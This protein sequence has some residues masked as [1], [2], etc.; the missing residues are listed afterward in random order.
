MASYQPPSEFLPIFDNT[1][2]TATNPTSSSGGLTLAQANLLYLRK[3]YPDVCT[4]LETFNGGIST[5][6]LTS[7][8]NIT[9]PIVSN[10]LSAVL[11]SDTV[12]VYNNLTNGVLNIGTNA[13]TANMNIGTGQTNNQLSIGS[14][15]NTQTNIY[16]GSVYLG[17]NTSISGTLGAN[18]ITGTSYTGGPVSGTTFTCTSLNSSG[19]TITGGAISGTSYS[20]GTINGTSITGTS[21][22][23]TG[24]TITG[25]AIT[26]TS[27]SG[28]SITGTSYSGGTVNGTAFTSTSLNTTNGNITMGTGNIVSVNNIA[29]SGTITGGAITG[30][31]YSGGT[32]N[33]TAFTSTSLNTTNGNITMGTGNIVSVNN[34]AAS[35][36]ITGTFTGTVSS[37]AIVCTSLDATAGIIK[38]TGFVRTNAYEGILNNDVVEL[39]TN[40]VSGVLSFGNNSARTANI[41]IGGGMT[42]GVLKLGSS[43][44]TRLNG[45]TVTIT[46]VTTHNNNSI[47]NGNIYGNI[48]YANNVGDSVSFITNQTGGLNSL[49]I[50]SSTN[51]QTNIYG[52]TVSLN[53][54]TSIVGTF[55]TGANSIT[56]TGTVNAGT[57]AMGSGT[58][59]TTG[60][61]NAG[62]LAMGSGTITTTGTIN[63]G[64][65]AMGTGNIT[66]TG[67]VNCTT[68]ALAGVGGNITGTYGGVTQTLNNYTIKG[69]YNL[70]LDQTNVSGA[71]RIGAING[72]V[73]IGKIGTITQF[74]GDLNFQ[75]T[76]TITGVGNLTSNGT[77]TTSI[78]K[79]P[80]ITAVTSADSITIGGDITTGVISLGTGNALTSFIN[81][82]TGTGGAG[83]YIGS[84]SNA[85]TIGNAMTVQGLLVSNS[86][87]TGTITCSGIN[88]ATATATFNLAG[89]QTSGDVNIAGS[90]TFSGNINIGISATGGSVYIGNAVSP[91]RVIGNIY[92]NSLLTNAISDNVN[93]YTTNTTGTINFGTSTTRT[94]AINIGTNSTTAA[95]GIT[96]GNSFNP[97]TVGGNLTVTGTLTAGSLAYTAVS[98][99]TINAR[100]N[101]STVNLYGNLETGPLNLACSANRSSGI[102]IGT[103]STV[104]SSD[105]VLGSS[106]TNTTVNGNLTSTIKVV[107]P[108]INAAAAG[109]TVSLYNTS[110]GTINFGNTG[111]TTTMAGAL[112]VTQNLTANGGLTLGSNQGIQLGAVPPTLTTS[113]LGYF[114]NFPLRTN[115]GLTSSSAGY[116]YNP[117][118]NTA[119][120]G[121]F[122]KAGV[123]Y[124]TINVIYRFT[125]SPS[126][127]GLN[128]TFGISSSTTAG[129]ATTS[130]NTDISPTSRTNTGTLITGANNN[131][132]CASHSLCFTLTTDSYLNTFF[133][134]DTISITGGTLVINQLGTVYR[135]A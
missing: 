3:N 28:G 5:T 40:N 44:D 16:G 23:A 7:S 8:G 96:L 122:V 119:G 57:L 43:G 131:D 100:F 93:L 83:V 121:N 103:G 90:T 89:N 55:S 24:G 19:G 39:F 53:G 22:N 68:L 69:T 105:I 91:L 54:N 114:Y 84:A 48:Y 45:N 126:A 135:I 56:T 38:T 113:Y 21:L 99:D 18:A 65:L 42:G 14:N 67:T 128:Y 26:G 31:S 112:T 120:A 20:G 127:F 77:I 133:S 81:I 95:L 129:T 4:V 71:V 60:T 35:G 41:N 66:G 70:V 9:G 29:A 73:I 107:T 50:G 78:I 37:G 64:T 85:V 49:T 34:I 72:A 110:T 117:A 80:T 115:T 87:S 106:N 92:N 102:N 132:F 51:G 94:G 25:G 104:S 98:I 123:Y 62:T 11:S 32:V 17:N 79:A 59:T 124:A 27:Y 46:G 82:G 125:S 63:A 30:T 36:T 101:S 109:T 97:V 58:I 118:T 13:R 111:S 116:R 76:G 86:F 52:G 2:F 1:V 10:S 12:N 130:T 74:V 61:I 88:T 108:V 47:F 75:N 6:F 134:V 33:G 15:L